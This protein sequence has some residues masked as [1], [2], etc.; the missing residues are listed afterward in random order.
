[1]EGAQNESMREVASAAID[2]AEAQA[3]AAA[4][5]E[6]D[7]QDDPEHPRQLIPALLRQ[8]YGLGWVTGTGGG[9]TIRRGDHIYIA[10]SGVHKERVQPADL[11]VQT[12]DGHDVYVPGRGLRRSACTQTFLLAYRLRGAGAV[13]HTHSEQALL[14]TLLHPGGEFRATHL[15]MIK[16][17]YSYTLGR[18]L[19]YDERLVVPIIENTPLEEELV[20]SM[21]AAMLRY[22]ATPAVLVRRHGLYVWGDTWQ[23]AKAVTECLDYVFQVAVEMRRLGLD[24]DRAPSPASGNGPG[25]SGG[26]PV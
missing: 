17:V 1:M 20:D 13:I 16:G 24:P 25:K 10:P 15:E 8:F 21:E 12:E 3:S 19:R 5:A 7:D 26:S 11:F 23:R 22:P 2:S 14:A 18:C 4:P 9:I 6:R